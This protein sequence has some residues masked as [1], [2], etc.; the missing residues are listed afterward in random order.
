MSYSFTEKKRIRKN[1]S[2]R[3]FSHE[4]PYLLAIQKNS[5]HKLLQAEMPAEQRIDQGLQAAFKSVFPIESYNGAASLEFV[6]YSLG[7]PTFDVKECQQR[8]MIYAAPLR[9]VLR[10]VVINKDDGG[11]GKSV[12]DVKEQDVYMGEVPLMTDNGTFIINGTERVVVSQLHRSP[13]VFFDHDRGKTHASGKLLFSARVIPYR[14]SWLD[15]EFDPKDLLFIRIDRRRKLPGTILLRALGFTTQEILAMFFETDHFS[16]SRAEIKIDLVAARLRGEQLDFDIKTSRGTVL[17]E[18]GER[19]TARRVRELEK[20]GIKQLVVPRE[21][22]LAR[23]LAQDIVDME[24]GEVLA[25]ANSILTEELFEE[26][27]EAG[28]DQ[29]QTIY[30]NDLD[31]GPY[32][33]ATL[34]VDPTSNQLEAQVEIYRMMRPG[35]PPTKEAAQNLFTNLFFNADRYDLSRSEERRVGKECRSRWSPYH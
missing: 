2:K 30:T 12:R 15:L 29:I 21:F 11:T 17:V 13:G 33:S 1:F 20:N 31:R 24:T 27:V 6:S 25:E 4:L 10:L 23:S 22:L 28:V 14:G 18:A 26:L 5:Y 32:I 34:R 19:I 8:G 35:E 3:R 9:A 7:Q 16:I